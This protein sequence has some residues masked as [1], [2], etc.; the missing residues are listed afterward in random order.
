MMMFIYERRRK[1]I[2]T[3]R[4]IN[5]NCWLMFNTNL[6]QTEK[7]ILQVSGVL[8]QALLYQIR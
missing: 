8:V 6:F 3:E 1:L 2:Y 5:C 7:V 4:K